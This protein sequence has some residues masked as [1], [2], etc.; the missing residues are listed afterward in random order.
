MKYVK[1]L[2]NEYAKDINVLV[3]GTDG[4]L[5]YL[6][7][8][9]KIFKNCYNLSSENININNK[10]IKD[11]KIDIVIVNTNNITAIIKSYIDTFRKDNTYLPIYLL[12]HKVDDI[13]VYKDIFSSYRFDGFIPTPYKHG[14]I[15]IYF[16]RHLKAITDLKYLNLYLEALD[17]ENVCISKE[18]IKID[19]KRKSITKHRLKDIRFTQNE[20]VSSD[21]FIQTLDELVIDKIELFL[22]RIDEFV[23]FVYDLEDTTDAQEYN[24][25]ISK[26]KDVVYEAYEI[27]DSL[28]V[29]SVSARAF[30]TLYDFLT[31][32]DIVKL[33]TKKSI[34][35]KMLLAIANDLE[36]WIKTIFIEQ[37]TEDIHYFDASFASNVL[38]IENL[39]IEE[40][41]EDVDD[42]DDIDDLE[43][44]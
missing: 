23:G 6:E 4:N 39:F 40:S 27:I 5:E 29:F 32:L 8:F 33:E 18:S 25:I 7:L 38:E 22:E 30:M 24:L 37:N 13:S 12:P 15:Y 36:K 9:S 3:V 34:F 35:C 11:K 43:F 1:N 10:Y 41:N 19:P 17:E 21:E 42:V 44:F 2:V 16:Y 31:E 20:K 26:L 28:I 14:Y